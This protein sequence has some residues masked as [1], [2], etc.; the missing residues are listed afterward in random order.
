M[1]K[2]S[3]FEKTLLAIM[4]VVAILTSGFLIWQSTGFQA[5]LEPKPFTKRTETEA[6]P[7]EKVKE[8]T[9]LLAK[10]FNWT[11]PVLAGKPVPLNKSVRV[12]NKGG[13]LY[14]MYSDAKDQQLRDTIT[15]KWLLEH[16]IENY[17]SPN[18]GDLDPDDD[19]FTNLEE[20]TAQTNPKDAQSHPAFT[21]HLFFS[22]RESDDY[23]LRLNNAIEPYNVILLVPKATPPRR[24][25]AFISP[26]LP[27]PF[28]YRDPIT[29]QINERFV[30]E[31]FATVKKGG[32]DVGQLIV[33]DK[34]T[35]G[36]LTLTQGEDVN[37]ASYYAVFEYRQKEVHRLPPVKEGENF[38]LPGVG[39]TFKL[40]K[41]EEGSAVISE[42][43]AAGK[44][45]KPM[46]INP[47]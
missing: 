1:K 11:S 4:A 5:T 39:A 15:N 43:D 10:V 35:N 28:G 31:S 14:D 21:T 34:S 37:L 47:R 9:G 18:V 41:V 27:K 3:S 24:D 30:A 32:K 42:L 38:R 26:P 17:Q 29:R 46:P 40:L 2:K 8:A 12:I 19:G 13:K 25:S 44:E 16:N 36:K 33:T 20:F 7:L 22:K 23:I 6:P 45:G